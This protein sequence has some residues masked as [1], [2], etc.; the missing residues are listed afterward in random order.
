MMNNMR[1]RAL[2]TIDQEILALKTLSKHLPDTF[3]RVVSLLMKRNGKIVITGI[4]KSGFIG[5]KIAATFVSLGHQAVFLH[6]VEALH[7]DAGI[8]SPEDII[9]AISFSGESPEVVKIIRYIRKVFKNTIISISGNKSSQLGRMSDEVLILKVGHEGDPLG[10]APMASAT[11]TL[12]IG[13]MLASAITSPETFKNHHFARFHPGGTLGL[14]LTKVKSIMKQ[15]DGVPKISHNASMLEALQEVTHKKLGVTTVIG[16]KGNIV[17]ILTDGDIRRFLLKCHSIDN[18]KVEE[19]MT[20]TPK[21]IDPGAS[22]A[23]A[24]AVME[25][26]KI[27]TL[28]VVDSKDRPAGVIHLHDIIEDNITR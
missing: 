12:V 25:E 21:I 15:G 16:A 5:M 3:D 19:A 26:F 24:L 14:K 20:K 22:L 1:K 13:D 17:G 27:T 9:I 6:P 23:E 4:G 7:G 2:F 11:A 8:V 18:V 28:F 10:L